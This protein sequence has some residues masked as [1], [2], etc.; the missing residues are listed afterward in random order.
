MLSV[1]HRANMYKRIFHIVSISHFAG[2]SSLT[3]WG[4]G[5]MV[6]VY[7]TTFSNAFFYENYCIS[8]WNFIEDLFPIIESTI[9]HHWFRQWLGAGQPI[10]HCLNQRWPCLLTHIC[11]T[12]P[13]RVKVLAHGGWD[14]LAGYEQTRHTHIYIYIYYIYICYI[15]MCTYNS[16]MHNIHVHLHKTI[17]LHVHLLFFHSL[18]CFW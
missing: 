4:R 2:H 11:V 8:D 3:H 17:H 12:R 15:Y 5:N 14:I 1:C 9:F 7:H 18:N 16:H 13:Q 10:G 6:D